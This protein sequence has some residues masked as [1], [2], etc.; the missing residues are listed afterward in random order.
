MLACVIRTAGLSGSRRLRRISWIVEREA[1]F[2]RLEPSRRE[3]ER[4]INGS[5]AVAYSFRYSRSRRVC[6]RLTGI[7]VAFASFIRRR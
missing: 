7:S 5:R 2:Y 4:P 6:V 3:L 1:F